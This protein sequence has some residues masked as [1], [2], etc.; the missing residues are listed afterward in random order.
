MDCGPAALAAV[1]SGFGLPANLARL[2]EACQT[3][4]DGT[5]IDAVEA[6]A[7]GSGLDAEQV[8]IPA[9]HL[10]IPDAGALPAVVV[11]RRPSGALHFMVIWRRHG[12]L[13]QVM[14]PAVGRR[15]TT[16][17]ELEPD[18][19]R[20]SHAVATDEW[21]AWAGSGEFLRPLARRLAALRVA[22]D[23]ARRWVETAEGDPEWAGLARLDAVVRMAADGVERGAVRRGRE[24]TRLIFHLLDPST[25]PSAVPERYWSVRPTD[26]STDLM[27]RGAVL[28]RVSNAR[29]PTRDAP[30]RIA[31]A[32]PPGP[33]AELLRRTLADGRTAA[34]GIALAALAAAGVVLAEALVFR[35]LLEAS[36][37][38]EPPSQRL[39]GLAAVVMLLI[40]AAMVEPALTAGLLRAGR[41]LEGGLRLDLLRVLPWLGESFLRTR[42]LADLAERVHSLHLLRLAPP[43]AGIG[44][45]TA[46]QVVLTAG[47]LVWLDP[48]GW[49]AAAVTAAAAVGL[50]ILAMPLMVEAELRIRAHSASVAE[51]ELELLRGLEPVRIH[52]SEE[53][54]RREHADRLDGWRDASRRLVRITSAVELAHVGLTVA[55]ALWLVVGHLARVGEGPG[56]LLLAYWALRLPVLAELLG[57]ILRQ[58]SMLKGVAA[59]ALEPFGAAVAPPRH[60][61]ARPGAPAAGVSVVLDGVTVRLA[62]RSV[63]EGVDLRVKEGEW[64]AVVGPSGAGK[65]TLVGLLL[66]RSRPTSGRLEVDGRP[67]DAEAVAELRR[68]TAWVDPDVRVWNRSLIDNLRYGLEADGRS[69]LAAVLRQLEL[70]T[71]ISGLEHGLRT[72]LGEGGGR[73]SGSEGQRVRL[74]RALLRDHVRLVVLDEALRGLDGALRR[75]VLAAVRARWPQAT[76]MAVTHHP[77]DVAAFDRVVVVEGGR[78]IEAGRPIELAADAGSRYRALLESAS[79]PGRGRWRRLGLADRRLAAGGGGP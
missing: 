77:D 37:L 55:G 30:V 60:A 32:R 15:W 22:R 79:T 52:G 54:V 2:R 65:S 17:K 29:A 78:V 11:V 61:P 14:D 8:M 41:R 39:A 47:A 12:R 16:W 75:S 18:V 9:D 72:K 10:P 67:L 26:Q 50:P 66:G 71:V 49:P 13:L 45:E 59:R 42:S 31:R 1:L 4:V 70:D 69:D 24:A 19:Y 36:H 53:V 57:R 6:V 28:V 62:G 20:H 5:S 63:L 58:G 56:T 33:F 73:L 21:R 34:V 3:D 51:A 76:V 23:R 7:A 46:V 64:L 25:A 48:G 35:A 44:L 43:L 40:A 74:A 38:L 27:L 68:S